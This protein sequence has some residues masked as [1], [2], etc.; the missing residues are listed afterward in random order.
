VLVVIGDIVD[1]VV[2]T[3]AGPIERA[4][5]T[6]AR[7]VHRRGGSAANVASVVASLGQA[8]RFVGCVGADRTGEQ[9]VASLAADGVDVRCQTAE[10]P[11]GTV[12]VLVDPSGERTMLNDRG[13]N[14]ELGTIESSR[15][16]DASAL[17]VT[18]YSFLSPSVGAAVVDAAAR[19]RAGGGFVS[20]DLSS[21]SVLR[22]LDVAGVV[23]ALRPR[24]VFANEDEAA[25]IGP[26]DGLVVHAAP[27]DPLPVADT[28][29][30]GD[31]FAAGYLV[32]L[33]AG[34][35]DPIAAGHAAAR[36]FLTRPR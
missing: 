7:V 12:I 1:D 32:A 31:A 34:D 35:A 20:L 10:S 5:D 36:T 24:V 17:H 21:V 2:V 8:V 29:G 3:L 16:D 25:F 22:E 6:P 4:T 27:P 23:A 15:L 33:L 11:T 30:S 14:A 18:A 26:L 28:T 9:L 13:A 19:V